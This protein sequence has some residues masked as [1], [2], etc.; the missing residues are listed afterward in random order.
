MVA[1]VKG[2]G[3]HRARLEVDLLQQARDL[4]Q[5]RVDVEGVEERI[6]DLTVMKGG[7]RVGRGGVPTSLLTRVEARKAPACCV[8]VLRSQHRMSPDSLQA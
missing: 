1:R 5:E 6:G 2:E 4:L 8:P 7:E 3:V